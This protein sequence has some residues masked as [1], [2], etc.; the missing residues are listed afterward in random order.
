MNRL[1]LITLGIP[2][3]NALNLVERTILSALNQTYPNIEY[4]FIDDKGNSMDLVRQVVAS[5]PR[6]SSVHIIDQI[7]NQGTGASRNAIILNATGEY[8]FTMDCDDVII[9]ECIEILYKKM[10]EHPVD[11]IAASFVRKDVQGV[12]YPGGCQYVDTLIEGKDYAVADYRYRQGKNIFVATWNK[13]YR[14]EFLR[15]NNIKCIPHYLIDDPWFTYQVIIC[16]KSCRLIA[17]NTLIFTY[18]PYS[19]TSIKEQDGYTELLTEQYLGT[20]IMKA[21]CLRSLVNKQF[22]TGALVDL[23]KMSLYHLYRAYSSSKIS[24]GKKDHYMHEFLLRRFSIPRHWNLLDKNSYKV[25][26]LLIFYVLPMNIKIMMVRFMV[27]CNLRRILSN[28]FHF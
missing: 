4:L 26:P 7:H 19:V 27:K 24:K 9:P 17:E 8:L 2:I 12:L 13:L 21:G 25:F 3:Y 28:W 11:F 23:M 18:N 20:Q 10:E 1:P 5:H 14:T 22:Y 6:K 16:A 15:S